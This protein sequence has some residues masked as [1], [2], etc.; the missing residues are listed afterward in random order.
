MPR[1]LVVEDERKVRTIHT[2]GHSTRPA[3]VF[4]GLLQAH[5][6]AT[7]ADVRT[8][9]RSRHNPQ[10]ESQALAAALAA[11]G[12][13]YVHL[14]GLGGLRRPR[15]DSVNLG[16]RSAGFRGYADHM[17]TEAF[18]RELGRLEALADARPTAI[19]CA[20]AEPSRCHRALLA[21]ALLARGWRVCHILGTG[22]VEH[23]PSPAMRMVDGRPVYP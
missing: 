14:P 21:D 9:P 3:E 23:A 22:A 12:L 1:I 7:L 5:G 19:M 13:G 20:E 15:P 2:I 4:T 6:I 18:R 10:F 11:L 8:V 17:Q 16:L